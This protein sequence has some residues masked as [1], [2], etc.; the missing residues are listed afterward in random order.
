MKLAAIGALVFASMLI[1]LAPAVSTLYGEVYPQD[2]AKK[3]ALRQCYKT[4][5]AFNRLIAVARAACYDSHR[6][7]EP[8]RRGAPLPGATANRVSRMA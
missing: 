6:N 4:D 1:A 5:P 8:A 7:A 3:E 2:S